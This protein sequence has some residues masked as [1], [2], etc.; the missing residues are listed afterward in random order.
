MALRDQ[1][2]KLI[3]FEPTLGNA[4]IARVLGCSRQ[5]VSYHARRL[6]LPREGVPRS[7]AGGCGRRVR[8]GLTTGMCRSCWRTS[9]AYEFVCAACGQV[10]VV[11][12]DLA[13]SRR[14]NAKHLKPRSQDYCDS[15][16][17]SRHNQRKF[18]AIRR[19]DPGRA[20]VL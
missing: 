10:R 19:L 3:Q 8:Q 13:A 15:S 4:E 7:C 11:Y 2:R 5:N 1:I 20:R 16:C 17:A 18:R 9:Y 14:R 12:G 6:A